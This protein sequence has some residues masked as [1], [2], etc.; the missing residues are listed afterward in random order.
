MATKV[1]S[2]GL[3]PLKNGSSSSTTQ[4][5]TESKPH[6]PARSSSGANHSQQQQQQQQQQQL[7][8]TT[9]HQHPQQHHSQHRVKS[10]KRLELEK[11]I[12]EFQNK[13]GKNW[14]KYHETLSLFLVG[15][16]SRPELIS[17]IT[18]FLKEHNLFRYHNK[19]LMLN[20]ANSLKDGGSYDTTNEFASFWNKRLSKSTRNVKST[21]Y[22]KFKQNIMGLPIKER[23]RI[24]NITRDSGKRN[25]L[26]AG[27]TLT[28]HTLLPKIPMIQDKEQQ[29]MQVN[30]LVQ[31][32]QD[33]LNGINT[34]IATENYEIPD[35]DNLTK[36]MLMI[37]REHGLTGGLN[38]GVLEVLLLGLKSHMK[39][40]VESAIDVAKYRKNKYTNNDYVSYEMKNGSASSSDETRNSKKRKLDQSEQDSEGETNNKDIIL[41]VEDLYDTFE[42]FPH[43]IEPGGPRLRLSNVLL[44]NDDCVLSKDELGYTLPPKPA[45]LMFSN[46]NNNINNN[47]NNNNNGV[48]VVEKKAITAA[49]APL[50]QSAVSGNKT[51]L[52]LNNNNN[53]V[54][55]T[56]TTGPSTSTST[57]A[58]SNSSDLQSIKP[59]H[60]RNGSGVDPLHALPAPS[61]ASP[62]SS[63]PPTQSLSQQQ[64]QQQK[65]QQQQQSLKAQMQSGTLPRPDAH[66]GSTD[67]LKWVLHDLVSTM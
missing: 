11:L 33:V 66:I 43:L 46:N 57:P 52:V 20:F 16:L 21:Q 28:R 42:M 5:K 9:S 64:Q 36:T 7:P 2:S 65:Q 45:S 44:E 55:T 6:V 25:K 47:N 61:S 35:A 40:V 8:P 49:E 17:T 4:V 18:P 15:K 14:E 56:A 3:N 41:S 51:G 27:I 59:G 19:L 67:E 62:S 30:N 24:K 48:A 29:Q 50:N 10:G 53:N 37:M 60:N 22:E 63:S 34:P 12:R 38:A 58:T 39:N 23:R 54:T 32:Q 31:W 1:I 13:L 26:N